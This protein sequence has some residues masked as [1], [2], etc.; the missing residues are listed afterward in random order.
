MNL[1]VTFW[2]SVEGELMILN[3]SYAEV[4]KDWQMGVPSKVPTLTTCVCDDSTRAVTTSVVASIVQV[5]GRVNDCTRIVTTSAVASIV[6]VEGYGFSVGGKI[7]VK[8]GGSRE[9]C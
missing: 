5:E 8:P 9:S 7:D 4:N 6:Q 2:E 3:E 1:F